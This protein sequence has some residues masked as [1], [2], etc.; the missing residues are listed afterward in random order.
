MRPMSGT[1]L[2]ISV[3]LMMFWAA[4]EGSFLPRGPRG[5]G[6]TFDL[7]Y[8]CIQR[9]YCETSKRSAL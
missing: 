4:A 1:L 2:A 5:Y 8:I 7:P 6:L 9:D 3:S